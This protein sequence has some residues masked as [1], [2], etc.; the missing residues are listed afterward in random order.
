MQ[1]RPARNTRLSGTRIALA[2]MSCASMVG[3]GLGIGALLAAPATPSAVA[4]E[5]EDSFVPVTTRKYDDRR[6]VE[7]TVAQGQHVAL[8]SLADGRVTEWSC[9]VGSETASSGWFLAVDG[10]RLLNV[11]TAVPPWRDLV[12]G[13]R[14]QDVE[15]LQHELVRLGHDVPVD[16]RLDRRTWTV[17]DQLT[18]GIGAPGLPAGQIPF[19][20][21][22]W[23]PE[24]RVQ[25]SECVVGA[26]ALAAS[27]DT[28]ATVGGGLSSLRIARAPATATDGARQIEIDDLE[29]PVAAGGIVADTGALAAIADTPSY[30][31]WLEAEGS[32]TITAVWTLAEPLEVAVVPAK[33]LIQMSSPGRTCVTVQGVPVAVEVVGSEL[34][35][36]LVQFEGPVPEQIDADPSDARCP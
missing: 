32:A 14:G 31:S 36:S 4:P 5:V 22:V 23:L 15:A 6:T 1:H 17:V 10:Q 25:F 11:A 20:S 35:A 7:L 34:G 28:V 3:I 8:V 33:A 18:R 19:A 24:E 9:L 13:D 30:R 29:I 16:G 27:G 12:I 26:G 21:F 2:L